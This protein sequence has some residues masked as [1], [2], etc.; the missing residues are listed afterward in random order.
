MATTASLTMPTFRVS[1]NAQP[2]A[3]VMVDEIL[4]P[5]DAAALQPIIE[6]AGGVFTDWTGKRTS[7]G[8]NCIATNG[9]LSRPVRERLGAA[10][11]L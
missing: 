9:A 8:G 6:E 3:E 2:W 4:S 10:G 7:F 1:V 5:W 11:G